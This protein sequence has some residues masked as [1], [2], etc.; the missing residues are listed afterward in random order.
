MQQGR[1]RGAA[2]QDEAGQ[3]RQFRVPGVAGL[4]EPLRV[5]GGDPQRRELRVGDDGRA[6]VGADVEQVVLDARQQRAHLGLRP[7]Q[8]QCDADDAVGLVDVGVGHQTRVG[9][10]HPAHVTE[11]RLAAVPGLRVDARQPD[12]HGSRA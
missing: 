7:A 2:G 9:L 1:G 8:R 10:G 5:G 11:V 6:Q 12:R 3:V 4:L